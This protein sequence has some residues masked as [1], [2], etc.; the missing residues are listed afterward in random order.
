MALNESGRSLD[1][2]LE[3]RGLKTY[4]YLNQGIVRA[5]DGVDLDVHA[6]CT[7]GIVGESGCGKSV[8]AQSIMRIVPEPPA[9][10]VEGR[11]TYHGKQGPFEI[12]AQRWDSKAMR[13]I[14]GAEISYIFQEPM[15]ALS[16]VHTIGTQIT[17]TIRLHNDIEKG[18]A[19]SRA[20]ELLEHVKIPRPQNVMRDYVH[21]LSG[22]M[23]QRAMIAQA[24]SCRPRVLI[25]DEPTTALDVT[26]Q[27]QILRLI[28]DLQKELGMAVILIT[29][30]MGVIA[31]TADVVSVVYLG[32]VVES[33]TVFEIFDNPKH[34]Y[35]R[36]LFESIPRLDR[37]DPPRAITGSV[38]GSFA[39]VQ[40]CAFTNRCP[41]A[42]G[43]CGTTEPSVTAVGDGHEVRCHLYSREQTET[44]WG[45]P[46]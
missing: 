10:I 14:R 9:R 24:L 35:T 18:E 22:G 4:F 8:T 37:D 31:Q 5:V 26:M 17:E 30:D 29:H 34:P 28:R 23:R 21:Q 13:K 19:W 44:R 42:M 11:I 33:G 25:A 20:V 38:P 6:G 45:V 7:H 40:G 12:T 41:R 2:V 1:R 27:A 43:V 3:V 32:K 46:E 15:S 39:R 36:A 16:P